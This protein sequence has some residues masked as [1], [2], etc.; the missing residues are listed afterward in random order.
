MEPLSPLLVLLSITPLYACLSKLF[1]LSSC[2]A[3][4]PCEVILNALPMAGSP[5]ELPVCPSVPLVFVIHCVIIVVKQCPQV[6]KPRLDSWLLSHFLFLG[7]GHIEP[8]PTTKAFCFVLRCFC[9]LWLVLLAL[10]FA[11]SCLSDQK[12]LD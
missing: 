4:A 8:D 7:P 11:C 12:W 2:F 9:C 10:I 6:R 5:A 3:F 1:D